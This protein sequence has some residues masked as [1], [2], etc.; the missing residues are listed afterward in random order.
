MRFCI[1]QICGII[2]LLSMLIGVH[3]KTKEKI[4]LSSVL[5][6]IAAIFQYF[7]LSAMIGVLTSILNTV[8]CLVFYQ[9][10]KK[11]L[12]PSL[13][14]LLIFE[15]ITIVM[16]VLT[17]QDVFSV[18]PIIGTVIYTYGLWQD[19]V[20]IIRIT[21]AVVGVSWLAYDVMVG[22]IV[23][24]VQKSSQT[25]SSIIALIRNKKISKTRK[26]CRNWK[27]DDK[28]C[29][30]FWWMYENWSFVVK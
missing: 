15:I 16:G 13:L 20:T 28:Y 18:L 4:L 9:Y 23:D 19:N 8:R 24:F 10:K 1:A 22:A 21:S 26:S 6:N 7:L 12:Q 5:A 29:H 17:W 11:D 2:V 14:V 25:I 27:K 3:F 30:F